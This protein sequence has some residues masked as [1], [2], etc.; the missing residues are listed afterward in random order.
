MR[1]TTVP[2]R[3]LE[4]LKTR[5]MTCQEAAEEIGVTYGAVK[6]HIVK[7][8]GA[9]IYVK[10]WQRKVGVKGREAAIWAAGKRKDAPKPVFESASIERRYR[11]KMRGVMR[12][13]DN[14]R[15]GSANPFL[16]LTWGA[17]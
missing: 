16:Q 12:M 14:A 3:L 4:A 5:P 7:M 13:R 10:D 1:P 11:E 9:S 2:Q 6:Y 17:R 8:H 15:R